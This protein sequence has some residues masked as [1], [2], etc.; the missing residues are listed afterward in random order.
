MI[1][2]ACESGLFLAIGHE[3]PTHSDIFWRVF[4][5]HHNDG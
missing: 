4:F 5:D 3:N 2:A 1:E